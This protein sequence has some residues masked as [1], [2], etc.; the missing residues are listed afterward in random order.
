MSLA[1]PS[2]R[3]VTVGVDLAAPTDFGAIVRGAD[4]ARRIGRDFEQSGYVVQSLR[5]ATGSLQALPGGEDTEGLLRAIS[6]LDR[7]ARD[8]GVLLSIGPIDAQKI[9]VFPL[10]AA[11][12]IRDTN[13]VSFSVPVARPEGGVSHDLIEQAA[14]AMLAIAEHSHGGVGNFRF[15]AAANVPSGTPFFPVA[16]HAGQ[17]AF[18][19]GLELPAVM[20]AAMREGAAESALERIALVLGR[21]LEQIEQLATKA[22][23]AATL[24][25]GGI[26]VSPAPGLQASIGAVIEG[27]T[28][29]PFGAA[30]TMAG[31]AALT[32]LLARLPVRRCGYSGLMLPVLEDLVLAQRAKEG[33]F[34]VQELLLYSSVCGT[35]LDV[36]PL[37][38]DIGT[39]AL[40]ALIGDVAALSD[41]WKKPLSARLFP[42][43]GKKAGDR[44]G[45]ANPHLT[46][47]IVMAVE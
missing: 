43:P 25:Y 2:I 12:L 20:L 14:E 33:C 9:E 31:C 24:A 41:R 32:G 40:S 37:P 36:V 30:G 7:F 17:V 46:D 4:S 16:H 19:L 13:V 39:A 28:G 38:G 5:L 34:G 15:A 47:S 45:F 1:R 23:I 18:S 10:W 11:R 35:G 8:H 21:E 27:V 26:D 22:A 29:R 6:D 42:T 3:T 44:V